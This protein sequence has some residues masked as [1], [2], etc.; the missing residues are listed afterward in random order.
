MKQFIHQ[1]QEQLGVK[2]I[3]YDRIFKTFTRYMWRT[4]FKYINYH[5]DNAYTILY[6][7]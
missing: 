7:L 2:S 6:N 4:S 1:Q 5:N 3:K